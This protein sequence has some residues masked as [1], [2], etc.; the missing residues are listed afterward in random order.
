MSAIS[1]SIVDVVVV[2]G[3]AVVAVVEVVVAVLPQAAATRANTV[4]KRIAGRFMC[5]PFV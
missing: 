3:A 5:F 2:T 1:G 4:K